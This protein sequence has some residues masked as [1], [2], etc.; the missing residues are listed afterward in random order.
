MPTLAEIKSDIAE[1]TEA[2][3]SVNLTDT[4]FSSFINASLN[5]VWNLLVNTYEDYFVTSFTLAPVTVTDSIDFDGSKGPLNFYKAIKLVWIDGSGQWNTLPTFNMADLD[6]WR[7]TANQITDNKD[8]KWRMI[9][10]FNNT[11]Y[12]KYRN[13]IQFNVVTPT[14]GTS[15]TT[16][17]FKLFYVPT[18]PAWG[19]SEVV[20]PVPVAWLDYVRYDVAA[21]IFTRFEI[22]ASAKMMMEE[23]ERVRREIC[24]Q[25]PNRVTTESDSVVDVYRRWD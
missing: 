25:A 6:R 8:L 2:N 4:V 3:T 17:C 1:L 22:N 12:D 21:R 19:S 5:A 11:G 18:M 9:S 20:F 14:A 15:G 10:V 24:G 16:S 13:A 23:R 7:V